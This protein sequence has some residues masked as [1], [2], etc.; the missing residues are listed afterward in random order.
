ML[1]LKVHPTANAL[2]V[3]AATLL[4]FGAVSSNRAA[5]ASA[6][7]AIVVPRLI[8]PPAAQRGIVPDKVPRVAGTYNG[9]IT[10]SAGSRE[11]SGT[12]TT[13]IIQHGL[14]I[15]GTF[16]VTFDSQTSDLSI[17]GT[18]KAGK[19]GAVLTFMIDDPKGRS[20][21]AKA[22]VRKKT[23]KGTAVVP[24]SSSQPEVDIVFR[25]KRQKK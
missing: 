17:S 19:K 9:S 1:R 2:V 23:L 24:P 14:R 8:Q 3:A 15:S 4:A 18:V 6:R 11:R 21:Q 12:V 25:A 16:D 13:T 20:A 22:T 5:P 7:G 10:E